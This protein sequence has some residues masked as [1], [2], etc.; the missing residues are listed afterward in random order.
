MFLK[1][2]Q[3]GLG[4]PWGDVRAGWENEISERK[5]KWL[6]ERNGKRRSRWGQAR[7]GIEGEEEIQTEN[8]RT[9]WG[10]M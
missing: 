3:T 1:G 9:V 10:K 7:G 4:D 5:G 8:E 2:E 6:A